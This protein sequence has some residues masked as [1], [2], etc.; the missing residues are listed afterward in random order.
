MNW[1]NSCK[2]ELETGLEAFYSCL[3]VQSK[4]SIAVLSGRSQLEIEIDA[5]PAAAGVIERFGELSEILSDECAKRAPGRSMM[6][7][8]KTTSR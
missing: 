2:D 3:F 6:A 8:D 4:G 1:N 5:F 7:E